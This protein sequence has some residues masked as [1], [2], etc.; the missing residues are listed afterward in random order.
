MWLEQGLC[1]EMLEVM[2][3]KGRGGDH[4]KG[5]FRNL[6][7]SLLGTQPM[8][9]ERTMPLECTAGQESLYD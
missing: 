2:L 9:V 5:L 4:H 7:L 1:R 6:N 8:A 3:E